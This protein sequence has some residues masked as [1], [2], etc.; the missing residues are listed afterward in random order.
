M[1]APP[2]KRPRASIGTPMQ[3]TSR[4]HLR[5]GSQSCSAT[6]PAAAPQCGPPHARTPLTPQ[7]RMLPIC[8]CL[9]CCCVWRC[10]AQGG[11]SVKA[12][13]VARRREHCRAAAGRCC[14]ARP[15]PG[16]ARP[17]RCAQAPC[18]SPCHRPWCWCRCA[19]GG[20]L[21]A[22]SQV[23]GGHK[24]RGYPQAATCF[25]ERTTFE[26]PGRPGSRQGTCSK[27]LNKSSS[28]VRYM[29]TQPP[30]HPASQMHFSGFLHHLPRCCSPSHMRH[31]SDRPPTLPSPCR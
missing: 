12:V 5:R 13:R 11:C 31:A 10:A 1:Q 14:P 2:C 9:C 21:Q 28:L 4:R 18:A 6:P 27:S 24:A 17:A 16:A 29:D 15:W 19:H 22:S 25:C 20:Q 26:F 8:L 3:V 7:V 23:V 30:T